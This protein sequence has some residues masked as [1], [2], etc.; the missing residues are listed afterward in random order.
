MSGASRRDRRG[1][2]ALAD[3]TVSR[4]VPRP[5]H[6]VLGDVLLIDDLRVFRQEVSVSVA[7]TS[8]QGCDLL[9]DGVAADHRWEQVWL[10]HDLGDLTGVEDTIGPV[11]DRLCEQA[12]AG[13]PVAVGVVVV[14]TTNAPAGASNGAGAARRRVSSRAGG[15]ARASRRGP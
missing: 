2:D 8:A 15:S 5:P 10:D 9:R 11:V 3:G 13:R 4:V 7:R 14:H 12:S 6:P 1:R